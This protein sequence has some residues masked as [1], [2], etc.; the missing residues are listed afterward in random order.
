MVNNKIIKTV[1][2]QG[3]KITLSDGSICDITQIKYFWKKRI[4]HSN[5]HYLNSYLLKK[6][7]Q[8]LYYSL[9]LLL[10]SKEELKKPLLLLSQKGD[11]NEPDG[12]K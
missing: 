12:N 3:R 10:F 1:K 4:P 8:R 2:K 6:M 11:K 7:F 5:P 9:P